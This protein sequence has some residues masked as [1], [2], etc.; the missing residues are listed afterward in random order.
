[1]DVNNEI[2][3]IYRY[4]TFIL[5]KDWPANMAW[6]FYESAIVWQAFLSKVFSFF[7]YAKVARY[8]NIRMQSFVLFIETDSFKGAVI[9]C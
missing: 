2:K 1:M 9:G 3:L 4:Y 6:Y 8:T 7:I 5:L